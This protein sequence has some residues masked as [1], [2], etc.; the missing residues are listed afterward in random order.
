M[1]L[2]DPDEARRRRVSRDLSAEAYE[3]VPAL[4]VEEGHRFARGLGPAVIVVPEE[5]AGEGGRAFLDELGD[6]GGR[7]PRTLV[8]L[9]ER[10]EAHEELAEEIVY[11]P[12]ARLE[13]EE[14]AQRLRRVLVG[15]ELDLEVDHRVEALVGDLASFPFLELVRSLARVGATGRVEL[16]R[17]QLFLHLGRL[18]AVS[19]VPTRGRK[20]FCRL[21]R[22]R[23]GPFRVVL[24]PPGE[25]ESTPEPDL[26]GGLEELVL[27]ALEDAQVERPDP[28]S[29]VH[30]LVDSARAV[31]E[32]DLLQRRIVRRAR[33]NPRLARLLDGLEVPDGRIVQA[34]AELEASGVVALEAPEQ[35]VQVVTDSTADLPARVAGR[36]GIEVVPLTVHFGDRVYRDRVDLQPGEFYRLLAE[37]RH[38]PESRPVPVGLFSE[39]YWRV[40]ERRDVVSVHISGELSLTAGHAATA[41]EAI[42]GASRHL[43]GGGPGPVLEVI[44]SGQVSLGLGLLALFAGRMAARDA[45]AAD[46]A[47]RIRRMAAE[48]HTLFMV[49]TLEYLARGGRIGKAQALL[50]RLF[51][52]RPILGLAG[53]EVVPLERVRGARAAL[54]RMVRLLT[55]AV[56]AERP[57][58]LA[59]AHAEAPARADR[60]RELLEESLEVAELTMAEIGPVVGTHA[61]P[62]CVGVAAYQPHPGEEELLAPI[63]V[64]R[65]EEGE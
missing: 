16:D 10:S 49:D 47:E 42:A 61:G 48:V 29:R 24:E 22:R 53:G 43:R 50:G 5:L 60:L 35:R 59:V 15:R 63:D 33:E 11:L 12:A 23:E 41:A 57:V 44:D 1:L 58:V 6:P 28:R 19:A 51:G 18:V 30:L 55:G 4:D 21:A 64:E 32:L 34:L 52:I 3:V 26:G 13:A 37:G 46:I 62:G 7:L 25:V 65:H 36:L 8:L 39:R 20:A 27:A 14:I 45:T 9:G 38:H 56:D 31:A 54:P 40:A 17:A 2:V